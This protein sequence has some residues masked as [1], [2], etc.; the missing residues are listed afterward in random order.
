[1]EDLSRLNWQ[2]RK[3][4]KSN[5]NPA[6]KRQANASVKLIRFTIPDWPSPCFGIGVRDQAV[7]F[8]LL[9]SKAGRSSLH[10]TDR[11]SYLANLHSRARQ[12]KEVF[13]WGEPHLGDPSPTMA[14][15]M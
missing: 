9:Q 8:A 4:L 6:K 2:K 1:V 12:A 5:S 7:P 11:R 3:G 10:L 14:P 15:E 13:A